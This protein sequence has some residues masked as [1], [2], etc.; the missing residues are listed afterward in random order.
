M[1]CRADACHITL[2]PHLRRF[3]VGLRGRQCPPSSTA[4]QMQRQCAGGEALA[5][6]RGC[7]RQGGRRRAP[8]PRPCPRAQSVETGDPG[9]ASTGKGRGHPLAGACAEGRTESATRRAVGNG[10]RDKEGGCTAPAVSTACDDVWSSES[11]AQARHKG[12][13]YMGF[14]MIFPRNQS[15]AQSA[16][17]V[18]TAAAPRMYHVVVPDA[19]EPRRVLLDMPQVRSAACRLPAQAL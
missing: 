15:G 2:R 10:R 4:P 7:C 16:S 19:R 14:S 11:T 1:H 5:P 9:N 13:I 12:S 8:R 17:R 6:R 3:S 18:R